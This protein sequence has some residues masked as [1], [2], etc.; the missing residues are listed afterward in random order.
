[1]RAK[2]KR[3]LS[4]SKRLMIISRMNPFFFNY[5]SKSCFSFQVGGLRRRDRSRDSGLCCTALLCCRPVLPYTTSDAR[6][7]SLSARSP[8]VM[9]SIC[10]RCRR[11]LRVRMRGLSLP[12]EEWGRVGGR[13]GGLAPRALLSV[14]PPRLLSHTC[15][16]PC[17]RSREHRVEPGRCS[18]R[19]IGLS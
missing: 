4:A 14:S 9:R 7:R 6:Q 13:G 19:P 3:C 15:S 8:T 18:C 11:P 12:A 1:M 17:G 2:S 5:Y 10:R 16:S